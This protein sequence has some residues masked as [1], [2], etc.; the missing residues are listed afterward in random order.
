MAE[1]DKLRKENEELRRRLDEKR[2][3]GIV[4]DSFTEREQ[5]VHKP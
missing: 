2:S 4:N 5:K 3:S 1:R